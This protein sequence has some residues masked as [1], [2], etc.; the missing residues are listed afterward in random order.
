M[1][2]IMMLKATVRALL[3]PSGEAYFISETLG[4]GL[5][6][7]GRVRESSLFIRSRDKDKNESCFALLLYFTESN[8]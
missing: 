7:R 6:K 5:K 1:L 4:Q 8:T 2:S 3:S